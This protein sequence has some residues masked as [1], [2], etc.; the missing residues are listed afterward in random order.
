MKTKRVECEKEGEIDHLKCYI[1]VHQGRTEKE[2]TD[3]ASGM[4][5]RGEKNV[6]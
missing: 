2:P 6:N 3:L 5:R 4:A 1:G